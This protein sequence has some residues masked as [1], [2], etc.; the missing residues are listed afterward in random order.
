[1]LPSRHGEDGN[2]LTEIYYFSRFRW[3]KLFREKGFALKAC[4]PNQLFY[5]GYSVFDESLSISTRHQL[6]RILGSACL[7]Y[8]LQNTKE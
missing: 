3:I 4:Y 1:L 2:S 6:S 7:I 8:V 5:T